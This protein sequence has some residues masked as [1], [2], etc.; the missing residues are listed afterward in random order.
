MAVMKDTIR[1]LAN[2]RQ[3]LAL[4]FFTIYYIYLWRV[5]DPALIYHGFGTIVRDVPLYSSGWRFFADA[6]DTPGG[7]V[8]YVHGFLSQWFHYAWLGA[9]VVTL[10]AVVLCELTRRHCRRADLPC[11]AIVYCLP[12]ILTLWIYSQYNHPLAA[13]LT[14]A[15]GLAI[16][17]AIEG[18][19]IQRGAI[20]MVILCLLAAIGYWLAGAG[21]VLVLALMTTVH[22]LVTWRRWL[23]ALAPIPLAAAIVWGLAECVFFYSPKLAFLTTTPFWH[24]WTEG[25]QV[26][27][28]VLLVTLFA[29]VPAALGLMGLGKLTINA[30]QRRSSVSKK[31]AKE[32]S[33]RRAYLAHAR[34]IAGP[35]LPLVILALGLFMTR[36]PAHRQ[37]VRM[38]ALSRQGRWTEVLEL[39]Q[40]LPKGAYNI[41]CNHDINRALYRY[42]RLGYDLLRFQQNPHALLLTHDPDNS[43]VIQLKMCATFMELGNVDLAEKLASEFLVGQGRLG[44][45]LE[46]LAWI[47]IIKGQEETARVYLN[48]LTGDPIYHDRARRMLDGLNNGFGPAETEYIDYLA[49]CVPKCRDGRL[50][51]KSVEDMLTGLLAQNP[52]N[53]M[54]FEYLMTSYLLAGRLDG[55]LANVHRVKDLGYSEIPTLYEEALL[56]HHGAQR[57]RLD[58]KRFPVKRQTL[59]RYKRFVQMDSAMKG[60]NSQA[61][62]QQ[63]LNEFGASYFFYYRFAIAGQ[64]KEP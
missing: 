53:K 38:N 13:C 2:G 49:A 39:G 29:F 19:P 36:D 59:E 62:F 3:W 58:M 37:I 45:V 10:T 55:I 42:G 28:K 31:E 24:P 18:L 25:V 21:A 32:K 51:R 15:V 34:K 40:S 12:A 47:N 52:Q 57:Q 44:I 8:L 23:W 22:L 16:S 17:Y 5:I 4:A 7:P 60:P 61:V 9:L 41:Y 54:A 30:R 27:S 1:Q 50:S 48:V 33:L 63:M 56:I 46:K 11:P 35:A 20:R 26:F 64:A 6:L 14:V 43:P